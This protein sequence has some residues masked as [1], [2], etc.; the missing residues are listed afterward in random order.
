M[1]RAR[2]P[3]AVTDRRALTVAVLRA[4]YPVHDSVAVIGRVRRVDSPAA[5][6][7]RPPR[8]GR[9]REAG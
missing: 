6:H 2:R 9:P 7:F 1:A 3:S 4:M 8:P 5:F